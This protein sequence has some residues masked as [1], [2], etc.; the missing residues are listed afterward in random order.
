MLAFV[1]SWHIFLFMLVLL[2][3]RC[4]IFTTMEVSHYAYRMT[5]NACYKCLKHTLFVPFTVFYLGLSEVSS[6]FLVLINLAKHFPPTP[7]SLI[8]QFVEFLCGPLFVVTFIYYRV[9]LWWKV[10]FLL[11]SDAR[12]VI[13]SG[14]AEKLR[15]GKSFV[16]YLFLAINVPLSILQVYWFWLIVGESSKVVTLLVTALLGQ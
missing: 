14:M 16:L 10:N 11:W 9:F 12:Q 2:C 8:H 6:I 15:P 1:F 5:T 7:G 3:H 13:A 4:S